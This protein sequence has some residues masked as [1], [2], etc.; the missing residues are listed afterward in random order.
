MIYLLFAI[1]GS[2]LIPVLFRAFNDWRVNVSWAIPIN[3]LVCVVVGVV[4]S[5]QGLSVSFIEQAWFKLAVTQGIILAVNFFLLAYTAQR[6]GV[7][8]AALA[9]RLSVVIPAILAFGLYGDTLTFIKIIGLAAALIALF[10][11]TVPAR[12]GQ[13]PGSLLIALLPLLVFITFG[14]YFTIIKY[15]QTYY[16]NDTNDHA[17]VMSGFLF[18][19]L[20]S[21]AICLARGL[22]ETRSWTTRNLGAGLLL[23]AVNY[24][25]VYALVKMLALEGWQNSQLYPVYSVGVV[26]VSSILAKCF[27]HEQLGRR[28]QAGLLL[29]LVAVACL[30]R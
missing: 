26:V 1:I 23:G 18:A 29:G 11:C 13:K 17:Y 22:L 14:G 7:A 3:Y 27:F 21:L 10:L 30:T 24:L 20:A 19:F 5:G 9:S 25:A 28:K 4:I 8:I 15:A 12:S 6:A 16:L 2:G